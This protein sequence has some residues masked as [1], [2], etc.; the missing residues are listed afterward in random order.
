M[1]WLWCNAQCS[2]F[3]HA[4]VR[5]LPEFQWAAL[6][7]AVVSLDVRQ[8]ALHVRWRRLQ[9]AIQLAA[10]G[11]LAVTVVG[12][13]ASFDTVD[14]CPHGRRS[15]S[16]FTALALHAPRAVGR[17]GRRR[18]GIAT[19]LACERGRFQVLLAAR[20]RPAPRHA[21]TSGRRTRAA[22]NPCRL[23]TYSLPAGERCPRRRPART[24]LPLRGWLG[25]RGSIALEVAASDGS[26]SSLSSN[27]DMSIL[28]APLGATE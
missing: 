2:L 10:C 26:L 19:G 3:T 15:E 4:H 14:R 5:L 6:A 24:T 20:T 18:V 27:C 1:P 22:C 16:T 11:W 8:H 23:Y 9:Q 7:S 17:A 13:A 25:R 21:H 12:T 28:L